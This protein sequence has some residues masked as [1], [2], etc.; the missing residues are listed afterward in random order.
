M[1][2]ELAK[3]SELILKNVK[4]LSQTAVVLVVLVVFTLD[5]GSKPK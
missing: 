5:H 4:L 2:F 3:F 1:N